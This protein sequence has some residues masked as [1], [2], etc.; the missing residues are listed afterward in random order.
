M[1]ILSSLW[2]VHLN[3]TPVYDWLSQLSDYKVSDYKQSVRWMI[4]Q[5]VYAPIT[6]EEIV[7]VMIRGSIVHY[8]QNTLFAISVYQ[9]WSLYK[10]ELTVFI[11]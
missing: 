6:F 2:L 1:V 11:S 5:G 9:G 3:L 10:R 4:Y 7:I 8:F